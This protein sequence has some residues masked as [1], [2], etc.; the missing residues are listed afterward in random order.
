MGIAGVITWLPGAI[1]HK[2]T[3]W[4]PKVPHKEESISPQEGFPDTPTISPKFG[5][6]CRI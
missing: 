1:G 3:Y 5:S 6:G 4:V 2:Y